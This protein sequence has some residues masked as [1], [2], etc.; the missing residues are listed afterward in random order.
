MA[1]QVQD[2][3]LR[4]MENVPK[5][6]GTNIR[7]WRYEFNLRL[8]HLEIDQVVDGTELRP[9]EVI[10]R[11]FFSHMW[12]YFLEN[13]HGDYSCFIAATL[14]P[15]SNQR[16]ESRRDHNIVILISSCSSLTLQQH[17]QSK[18]VHCNSNATAKRNHGCK[19]LNIPCA[20]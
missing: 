12:V 9:E 20:L 8:Q 7:E 19:H 10:H 1:G 4:V 3:S 18:R 15:Q 2:Q 6:D 17:V 13:Q 14:S 5:F 11:P 16:Y